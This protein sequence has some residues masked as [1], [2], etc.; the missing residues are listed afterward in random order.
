VTRK[1]HGHRLYEHAA[2]RL[3]ERSIAK[4]WVESTVVAPDWET[5]DPINRRLTRAYKRLWEAGN[6]VLRM[7]YF[8]KGNDILVITPFPDRDAE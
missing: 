4:E 5:P 7:V 3:S 2:R 6:R 1:V 8:K